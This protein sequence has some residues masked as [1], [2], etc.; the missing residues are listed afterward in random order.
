M[1]G[2]TDPDPGVADPLSEWHQMMRD[3][4]TEIAL[5]IAGDVVGYRSGGGDAAVDTRAVIQRQPF[6][7]GGGI[8]R[9]RISLL[10]PIGQADGPTLIEEGVDLVEIPIR[11]GIAPVPCRVTKCE[12]QPGY[13]LLEV[14][15]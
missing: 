11:Y 8:T 3:D 6:D 1:N 4:V 5:G 12:R 10:V 13:F 7:F 15:A 14:E 2:D 9:E